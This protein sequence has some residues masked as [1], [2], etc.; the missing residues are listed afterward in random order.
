MPEGGAVFHVLIPRIEEVDLTLWRA[1]EEAQKRG[2]TRVPNPGR[3]SS[4]GV[5][6]PDPLVPMGPPLTN[7]DKEYADFARAALIDAMLDG[8]LAISIPE[9][10][11][12]T[13][14]AGELQAEGPSPFIERSRTLILQIGGEDLLALRQGKITRED[15]KARIKESKFPN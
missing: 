3:V 10:K 2:A 11:H 12:L 7:P 6:E 14:M 15:A 1:I 13:I 5:V 9:G 8:A 4:T